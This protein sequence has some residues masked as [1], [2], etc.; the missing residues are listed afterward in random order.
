METRKT[1]SPEEVR[2]KEALSPKEVAVVLGCGR[3]FA[4]KLL[5]A[6]TI[7]NFKIGRKLRRVRRAALEEYIAQQERAR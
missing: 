5:A 3:T 2:H 6:G 4:Y 1:P 7:P